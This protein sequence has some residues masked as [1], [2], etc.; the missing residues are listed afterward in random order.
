MN[1]AAIFVPVLALVGWTLLI[2]LLI[3]YWRFRAAFDGEVS[4]RDF[5]YGESA[6]VPDAVSLAN[7][8]YMNL[9]IHRL[10]IFIISNLVLLVMWAR[11]L[12][13]QIRA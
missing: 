9:V 3:P 2:M 10:T 11:L 4:A 6:H 1:Q 7:R 12:S 13:M 8:N 5:R